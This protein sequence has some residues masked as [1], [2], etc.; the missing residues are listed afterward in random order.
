MASTIP[1]LVSVRRIDSSDLESIT[2]PVKR[3]TNPSLF[4]SIHKPEKMG[5][6]ANIAFG[7]NTLAVAVNAA[8]QTI[9]PGFFLYSAL[10]NYLGPA[11]TD[12]TLQCKVRDV[13]TTKTFATRHVELSQVQ[14]DGKRRLCLFLSADFQAAE[15][16][17][18]LTYSRPPMMSYSTVEDSPT[19]EENRQDCLK[20]GIVD[21]E[22]VELHKDIFGFCERFIHR[23]PC[24]EGFITQ[25]LTGLAKKGTP[26]TQDHLPLPERSSGDYFKSK[27][28]LT[29]AAEH[30]AALAFVMDMGMLA[31]TGRSMDEVGSQSS[32]EFALRVFSNELDLNAWCLRELSTV[33]GGDGRTYNEAQVW[34]GRGRML[35]NM[36]QQC[37]LRPKL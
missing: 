19:I 21:E 6:L 17:S 33:V 22:T 2:N 25:N 37:L 16:A 14:K 36:T 11:F 13:R 31:L 10:G 28:V 15:P 24:S 30:T 18:L 32:L 35:C 27:H 29:T 1:E 20:Q 7:G 12:R 23:R 9:P 5:N 26:T 8:L 34:D 4:E 3:Q